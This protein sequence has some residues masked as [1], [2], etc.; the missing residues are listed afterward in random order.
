LLAAAAALGPCAAALAGT[1]E[2]SV[3]FPG[4]LVPALTVYAS[5]LDT[6][7]VRMLQLARGQTS[8]AVEVPPG[9]YVVFLAPTEP[10]SP[11]VYGAYTQYSLCAAHDLDRCADHALVPITIGAKARQASVAIDDWYLTDEVAGQIDRMRGLAAGNPGFESEPLSAPRFSEYPSEPFGAA[12]PPDLDLGGSELSAQDRAML[13]Q[14]L[15][16]GPNFA[17]YLTATLTSCGLACGRFLLVDWRSGAVHELAL[18][19]PSSE[20]AE[21]LTLPCRSDETVLFRRDSRLL[22]VTRMRGK[23][24]VTQY[25]VWNQNS[26]ALVQNGEYQRAPQSFCAV[27]A[28]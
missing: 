2:G 10:G 18:Q 8:F 26:G 20:V 15:L 28:R 4:G 23:A 9:R 16:N 27:A 13:R 24:V 21:T 1:I 12:A 19:R 11:N 6:S 5:D 25:F 22:F 14:A 7:K 3:E 17:G